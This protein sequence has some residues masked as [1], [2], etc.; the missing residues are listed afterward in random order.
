MQSK[1]KIYFALYYIKLSRA[2]VNCNKKKK[3][4]VNLISP[5]NYYSVLGVRTPSSSFQLLKLFFLSNCYIIDLALSHYPLKSQI[6]CQCD[7][8]SR[9]YG[10]YYSLLFPSSSIFS[11]PLSYISNSTNFSVCSLLNIPTLVKLSI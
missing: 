7:K 4:G 5:G 3:K 6:S 2:K 9:I 11:P 10:C 1:I 8:F